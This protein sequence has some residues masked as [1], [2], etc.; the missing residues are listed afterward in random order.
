MMPWYWMWSPQVHFPL[1]G[2]V[3]QDMSRDISWF[4]GAIKPQAGVGSIEKE[5]FETAS[6]GKQLGLIL[7]VLLP[8]VDRDFLEP[9][10]A[11]K[12]LAELKDVYRDIEKVKAE[13][14]A[15]MEKAAVALLRKIERADPEMLSRVID[16]FDHPRR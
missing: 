5:V 7:D 9:E 15:E 16:Q 11:G 2:S 6:Y 8:L 10:K 13:S 3:M 4:F 14:R 1:S 12:S